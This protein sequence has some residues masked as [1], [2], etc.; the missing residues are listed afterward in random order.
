MTRPKV[1]LGIPTKRGV[2]PRIMNRLDKTAFEAIYLNDALGLDVCRNEIVKEFLKTDCEWLLWM[3]DDVIPCKNIM[4]LFTIP[5]A[6]MVA[7]Y[8]NSFI[9]T[10]P[11]ISLYQWTNGDHEDLGIMP[12]ETMLDVIARCKAAGVRP[13]YPLADVVGN[14]YAVKREVFDMVKDEEGEWYRLNWHDR[15]G[16]LHRG[17][18]TYFFRRTSALGL[19]IHVAFDVRVGHMKS[20]D[21][22]QL[23]DAQHGIELSFEEK[24]A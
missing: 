13:I 22:A 6:L 20:M 17:E 18:D 5:G 15:A 16:K 24:G 4:D 8:S 14:C 21:M 9:E 19:T 3:D 10:G 12:H 23:Y 7:P 1:F 2:A 11:V